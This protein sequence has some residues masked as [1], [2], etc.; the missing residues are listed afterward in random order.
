MSGI[1]E[2]DRR[3]LRSERNPWFVPPPRRFNNEPLDFHH[4]DEREQRRIREAERR[5]W[6]K[7][8]QSLI[9]YRQNI[10]NILFVLVICIGLIPVII[11]TN[12]FITPSDYDT[13][14]SYV[15]ATGTFDRIEIYQ[16]GVVENSFNQ[17]IFLADVYKNNDTM[18][19]A[20]LIIPDAVVQLVFEVTIGYNTTIKETIMTG[21]ESD[22]IHL[23][24]DVYVYISL[25]HS[26]VKSLP[27][28]EWGVWG[29][30]IFGGIVI[31][32]VGYLFVE[33]LTYGWVREARY[34]YYDGDNLR[35][36]R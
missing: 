29:Q 20:E 24:D 5:K 30:S 28:V 15:D 19:L 17:L 4:G 3:P 36:V 21:G 9:N 7:K 35:R 22:Y 26:V 11:G 13:Y 31:F 6:E 14:E 27:F 1:D 8:R 2:Q 12:V 33:R 32:I 23:L 16:N 18:I 34:S 25:S 10:R